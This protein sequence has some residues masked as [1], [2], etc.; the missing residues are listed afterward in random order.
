MAHFFCASGQGGR[1]ILLD[2]RSL[3]FLHEPLPADI[4]VFVCNS[5]V[6]HSIAAGGYESRKLECQTGIALLKQNFP[7]IKALRDVTIEQLEKYR[8]TLP[9]VIFKRCRHVITENER[10]LNAARALQRGDI[11]TFG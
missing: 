10:V 2:S 9:E 6:K 7:E 3:E 4:S 1:A 5:M 8:T 11:H